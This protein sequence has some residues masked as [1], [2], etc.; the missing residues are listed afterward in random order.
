MCII[1][2]IGPSS[3]LF[4]IRFIL[5]RYIINIIFMSVKKK[6]IQYQVFLGLG[7]CTVDL[8]MK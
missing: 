3:M 2:I 1:N 5:Y 8:V 7:F 4:A 6:K